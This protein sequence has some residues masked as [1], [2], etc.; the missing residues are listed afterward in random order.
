MASTTLERSDFKHAG[1]GDLHREIEDL[2]ARHA[3]LIDEDRLEEWPE[4]F[5][6]DCVYKIIARENVDR[7]LPISAI[8]CDSRKMLVDRVVSLRQANIYPTHHYRHILSTT[9]LHAPEGGA[10]GGTE[11]GLIRARTNYVVFQTRNNGETS[12]YNAGRYLDEIVR[13]KDGALRFKSKLA[14]FDTNRI[15]TLM[16]RPI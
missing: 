13:D 10:E 5:T 16:V 14:V 2:V 11:P 6:E 8:F 15:D 7:D 9:R 3:E 12:I 1:A 4:L